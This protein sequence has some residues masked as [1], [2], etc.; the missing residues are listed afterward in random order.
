MALIGRPDPSLIDLTTATLAE[1]RSFPA[2]GQLFAEKIYRA[3]PFRA[4]AELVARQ[5][6]P[7]SVYLAIKHHLYASPPPALAEAPAPELVPPGTAD[8]NLATRDELARIAEIGQQFG[9]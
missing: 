6:I 1:L 8:L 2:I 9:A 5:I 7:T 3:R 4:R